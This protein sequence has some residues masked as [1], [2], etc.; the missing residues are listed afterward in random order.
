MD[1]AVALG[2]G[3]LLALV[4][5]RRARRVRTPEVR[6]VEARSAAGPRSRRLAL[7][8]LAV[9]RVAVGVLAMAGIVWLARE[10]FR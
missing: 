2:A 10:L 5:F 9:L 1:A 7:A 4:A 3:F 8:V 6:R